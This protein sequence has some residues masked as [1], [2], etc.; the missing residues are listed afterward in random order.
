MTLVDMESALAEVDHALRQEQF[1][2]AKFLASSLLSAQY[3]MSMATTT[4]TTTTTTATTTTADT[5]A[6]LVP[7]GQR[8]KMMEFVGDAL[9]G[10]E[11]HRHAMV[12]FSQWQVHSFHPVILPSLICYDML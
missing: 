3:S 9:V 6:R 10:L 4:A 2:T 12:R 7:Q 5:T 1:S 8:A 11:E